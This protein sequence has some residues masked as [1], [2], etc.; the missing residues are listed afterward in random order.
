[1]SGAEF[2]LFP[3]SLGDCAIAWNSVGVRAVQLPE[4]DAERT[5]MRLRRRLAGATEALPP[6]SVQ[7]TIGAIAGLFDGV[8]NDL[9]FVAL[10][11]HDLPALYRDVYAIART[12]LPGQT[13]TYGSIA[14]ELGDVSLARAVGQAM[15]RNPFPIIVPCHRVVGADGA[16]IGFSAHG[17]I[18]TK[19][20]MLE[21]EGVRTPHSLSLF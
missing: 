3:T 7:A 21:I 2:C 13:R 5:R 9:Q 11:L 14:T 16:L 18:A 4:A 19:R 15:G 8:A 6:A 20:R 17:G 12:I 10:D 1:M